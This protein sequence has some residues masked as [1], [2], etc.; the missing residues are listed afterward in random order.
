MQWY[1]SAYVSPRGYSDV[2]IR[3]PAKITQ[4]VYLSRRSAGM[5]SKDAGMLFRKNLKVFRQIILQDSRVFKK[6]WT[7]HSKSPISYESGRIYFENY[8][9]CFSSIPSRPQHLYQLPKS[10]KLEK[11]EDVLLCQSPLVI[12]PRTSDQAPSLLALTAHNWLYR[13]STKT[14]EQLQKVCLSSRYKFRYLGWDV[15]QETFYIKSVQNKQSPTVRQAG[16]D[17]NA[18]I[19][20]AVF[21]VFPLEIVAVLEISK[22]VFGS[23]VLDVTLS[24]GV[25]VVSHSN[26]TVKLYSFENIVDKFMTRRLVLGEQCQWS[27]IS[28]TVGESPFGIPVNI[29]IN[30]CPPVLYELPCLDNYMQI[31][32]HPWHV[33]FT[34]NHKK[35]RGTYHI[36]LLKDG[37]LAHNGIQDMQCC[38]LE[39]DWIYFHPDESGRIIHVGPSKIKCVYSAQNSVTSSGRMVRR[40]FHQ[41][42]D[43]PEKETFRV[44]E[45]EDELDL[46]AVVEV[47][48]RDEKGRANVGLH[49]NQSGVLMKT[50]ELV[51]SWDVT[52]TH[53]LFFDQDTIVHIAQEKNNLFSCHVYKTHIS[54]DRGRNTASNKI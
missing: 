8:R 39:S 31:G 12:L 40:R 6:V 13:L 34:P 9:C 20:L 24:Q 35:H 42:D 21:Q 30:E 19:Y 11:I 10:S 50:V 15:P 22:R 46:L 38:S 28:G 18:M 41:L 7:R 48:L 26:K 45:Y 37:T 1:T 43:D 5:F 27:G 53:E 51:E 2:W 23:T 3:S 54:L 32:G 47:T 52:Y 17:N 16:L 44:V 49:D 36:C 4:N 14:G 29:H 25:L 33:I